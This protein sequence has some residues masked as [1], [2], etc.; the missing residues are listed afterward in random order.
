MKELFS[1]SLMASAL[2]ILIVFV[3]LIFL[4]ALM[5]LIKKVFD[6]ESSKTAKSAP[7]TA[8]NAVQKTGSS[9]NASAPGLPLPVIVAAAIA[10]DDSAAFDPEW[11]AAATAAYLAS[12]EDDEIK[13]RASSWSAAG[14]NKYDPWVAVNKFSKLA[15]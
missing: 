12:E 5:V 1:Y 11:I 15:M 8:S 14:S 6:S 10:A 9:S 3:L 2:G 7:K 4:S 13:P